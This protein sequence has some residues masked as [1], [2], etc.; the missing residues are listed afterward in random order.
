MADNV[1]LGEIIYFDYY[2][3]QTLFYRRRQADLMADKR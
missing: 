1:F 3:A 2:I